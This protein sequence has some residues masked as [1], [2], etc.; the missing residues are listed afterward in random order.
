MKKIFTFAL[1]AALL[2]G[3]AQ[4]QTRP[5]A[6]PA[7]H[8][9]AKSLV[10]RP[11]AP[12]PKPAAMPAAQPQPAPVAAAPV[13]RPAEADRTSS[14]EPL[15]KTLSLKKAA[16]R[17]FSKGSSALNLGVGFGLGYNYTTGS[18]TSQTP[19]LSLSY[20]YGVG[21][22]GP[23][24]ISVG[25]LVGYKSITWKDGSE[26]AT[27]RNIYA[28]ARGAFHY[29]FH[30][31]HLDAYAGLGVG[32][33]V[34]SYTDSYNGGGLSQSQTNSGSQVEVNSFAGVRYF[35]SEAIG[36]FAELGNDTS[37]LKLGLNARF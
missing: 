21:N 33:R 36:A 18:N 6:R 31:P 11:A 13:A 22:A 30:N 9:A 20:M 35:F 15:G 5:A 3:Q 1:A 19:A 17:S 7:T 29:G 26:S 14:P 23:G 16:D 25:A 34:A 4:A 10:K 8:P 32:L 24:A 2:A 12:A 37:Y 27:L 28:G